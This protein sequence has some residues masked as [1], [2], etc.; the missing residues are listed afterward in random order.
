MQRCLTVSGSIEVCSDGNFSKA[1]LL[2]VSMAMEWS[3]TP[4]TELQRV[5]IQ[6]HIPVSYA[7]GR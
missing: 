7:D 6:Y 4:V 1:V 2:V 3:D 5:M